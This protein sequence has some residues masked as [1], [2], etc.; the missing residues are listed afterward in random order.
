MSIFLSRIWP[1]PNDIHVIDKDLLGPVVVSPDRNNNKKAGFNV[2]VLSKINLITGS[3]NYIPSRK[4]E[5][6]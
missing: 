3:V 6:I 4:T 1:F 2:H 5:N